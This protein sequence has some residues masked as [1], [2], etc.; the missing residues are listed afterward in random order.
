[1]NSETETPNRQGASARTGW[2]SQ[3]IGCL[4]L[5]GTLLSGCEDQPGR[6]K[7]PV[8]EAP[9]TPMTAPATEPAAV[10]A[11]APA[12]R[13]T[14]AP[15]T[16]PMSKYDPTP[17]YPVDLHVRAPEDPQPGWL[18]VTA[19]AD[20]EALARASGVFPEKN[21]MYVETENVY[22]LRVYLRKLPLAE[23]HRTFLRIDGQ[24]FELLRK[25]RVYV[26]LQRRPT[27]EWDVVPD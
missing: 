19:L 16:Q 1:M 21:R 20:E 9:Q 25:G 5:T 23:G 8:V 14:T 18:R 11:T 22:G 10:S 4:I 15:A 2:R 6:Q 12:T 3:W 27:G 24:N 7:T 26:T 17:P 13:P